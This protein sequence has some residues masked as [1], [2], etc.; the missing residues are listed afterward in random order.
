MAVLAILFFVAF[1]AS[2]VNAIKSVSDAYDASH[3]VWFIYRKVGDS[4][5]RLTADAPLIDPTGWVFMH[6]ETRVI[7][8]WDR[9][10]VGAISVGLHAGVSI[11]AIAMALG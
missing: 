3:Q 9:I 6:E 4:S 10:V 2:F 5:H 8:A 7:W 11:W 1:M